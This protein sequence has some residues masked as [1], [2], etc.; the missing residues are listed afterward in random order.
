MDTPFVPHPALATHLGHSPLEHYYHLSP[1]P[2]TWLPTYVYRYL[3]IRV[4]PAVGAGGIQWQPGSFDSTGGASLTT[5]PALAVTVSTTLT[6][7][8]SLGGSY[9][10]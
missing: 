8:N 10:L 7:P 3:S 1:I 6:L 4:P 2:Y 5:A 9:A